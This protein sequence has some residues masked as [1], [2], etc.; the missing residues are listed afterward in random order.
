[1]GGAGRR[2]ELI[3]INE[4]FPLCLLPQCVCSSRVASTGFSVHPQCV[5]GT[6][7]AIA[8]WVATREKTDTRML[9]GKLSYLVALLR[10]MV[11]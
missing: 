5:L 10:F 7:L 9:L 3:S 8:V 4:A 6:Q 2:I 11:P 1:M